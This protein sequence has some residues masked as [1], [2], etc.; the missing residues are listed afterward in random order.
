LGLARSLTFYDLQTNPTVIQASVGVLWGSPG[1]AVS[2]GIV[3]VGKV[4]SDI[5]QD[6]HGILNM[7][8]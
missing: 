5:C 2:M 4:L 7:T 8:N 3:V 6:L 1:T